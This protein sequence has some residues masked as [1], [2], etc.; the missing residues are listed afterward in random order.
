[1]IYNL[2]LDCFNAGAGAIPE[3]LWI[4]LVVVILVAAFF[5]FSCFGKKCRESE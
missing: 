4:T 3:W 2:P 1:M 5:W